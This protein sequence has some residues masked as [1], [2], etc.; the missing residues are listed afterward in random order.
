MSYIQPLKFKTWETGHFKM[1]LFE[2]PR[3]QTAI[4]QTVITVASGH[5]LT[6]LRGFFSCKHFMLLKP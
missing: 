3:L 4:F 5:N 1:P 2:T 6:V